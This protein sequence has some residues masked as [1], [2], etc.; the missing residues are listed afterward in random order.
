L[1]LAGGFWSKDSGGQ[2]D[3]EHVGLS[4]RQV[5]SKGQIAVAVHLAGETWPDTRPG[6][7]PDVRLEL[8][9]TYERLRRFGGHLAEVVE[10]EL[11]SAVL[12]EEHLV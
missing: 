11:A 12:E 4:V 7:V 5:T 2:L 6:S 8:L 9:G 10:G 3:Q 1:V